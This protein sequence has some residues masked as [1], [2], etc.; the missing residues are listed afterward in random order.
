M[1]VHIL[2][3]Y[4]RDSGTSTMCPY[5]LKARYT[6]QSCYPPSYAWTV[7]LRQVKKLHAYMMRHL[8]SIIRIILDVHS[9][10]HG[11]T[12]TVKVVIYERSSDQKESPVDWTPHEHVT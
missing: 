3:D 11:N 8:H 10:K 2:V 12:R 5:R 7:Y 4:A 6:V 1:L 9:D